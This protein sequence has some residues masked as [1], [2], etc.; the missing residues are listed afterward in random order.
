MVNYGFMKVAAATPKL[1]VADT[2]YNG[3]EILRLMQE[4]AQEEC[5]LLVFPELSLTGYSCY[6]LFGQ[7]HLLD[8]ALDQLDYILQNTR[9]NSVL[10]LIGMPVLIK[11]K[12]YNCALVVLKGKILGLVAKTHLANSKEFYEKRWFNSGIDFVKNPTTVNILGQEV[13]CG[14]LL[15]ECLDL[16]FTLGVEI[17]ED[18]CSPLAPSSY[19]SLKGANII[20]NLSA[21][22]EYVGKAA[23]RKSLLSQQSASCHCA[24]IYAAAG[25]HESTTDS[26]FAGASAIYENGCSLKEMDLF[27]RES[28]LLISEVDSEMLMSRGFDNTG[29]NENT[30]FLLEGL[31]TEKIYFSLGKKFK[32]QNIEREINALPFLPG[33]NDKVD[34]FCEEVFALQTAG[35]AKRLEHIGIKKVIIG[36]SGGL[37]STL[38]LLSLA[39][40]YDFLNLD[41]KNIIGITMPGF[42][43]S[44]LTYDYAINL[45]DTL[46][47]TS[48]KININQACLRHFQDIEHD[49]NLVDVTYENV[50]A[51]ERTKILMNYANKHEGLVI[52]TG[53][54]SEL[55]LGW[56]TYN[57]DHM[58]MYSINAGIPK[59][60][61]IF[62]LKWAADKNMYGLGE[63]LQGIVDMPISPELTPTDNDGKIKQKTEDL[64]GPYELHDFYLYYFLNY[65]MSP[66]KILF[67]AEKA[68]FNKYNRETILKWLR[69]FYRR[70]FSQQFKRSCL[71]DGPKI[72]KVNLSPRG[73]WKMASDASSA[74]WLKE[75]EEL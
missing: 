66:R 4:A 7:K 33:E 23:I 18:V 59:T 9:E 64:V 54:L 8:S 31:K 28:H 71:P 25:V 75:L 45:M 72:G 21:T 19:L 44:D 62:L 11:Q 34:N 56:A 73:D 55:A 58:S 3:Q 74:I 16:P 39:K 70:F 12:L 37:D 51:R 42:G 2:I 13:I 43:T 17:G 24:Y 1:K 35:L 30:D 68:F 22:S 36:I 40:T 60:L 26:V 57:G 69:V 63:T 61:V 50:Q 20:A 52:G 14:S 15:F 27:V 10:T 38:A 32:R 46:G 5:A 29:F 47:V 48:K 6:D 41:R 53:D 67:L 65:G 49:E